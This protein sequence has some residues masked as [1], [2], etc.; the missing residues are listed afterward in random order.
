MKKR[1]PR[2][3]KESRRINKMKQR[4]GYAANQCYGGVTVVPYV[5][6]SKN[7]MDEVKTAADAEAAAPATTPVAP[8][9][10][11]ADPA[12]AAPAAPVTPAE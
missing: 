3:E 8:A 10:E 5:Q 9:A 12:P 7:H 4:I 11:V 6:L 2:Q 1:S